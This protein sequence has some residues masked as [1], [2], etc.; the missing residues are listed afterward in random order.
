MSEPE[1]RLYKLYENIWF[2]TY[3]CQV[4][5]V[6][7]NTLNT[8]V[9]EISFFS[10]SLLSIRYCNHVN[11]Y[12]LMLDSIFR[13]YFVS[14]HVSQY[15]ELLKL[16]EINFIFPLLPESFKIYFVDESYY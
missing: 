11:Q 14:L 16:T 3:K 8:R 6:K 7:L 5:K 13:N 10:K 9:L 2:I 1:T 15:V 12:N 4:F